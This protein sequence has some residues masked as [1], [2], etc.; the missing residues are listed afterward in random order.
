MHQHKSSEQTRLEKLSFCCVASINLVSLCIQFKPFYK[1]LSFVGGDVAKTYLNTA[2]INKASQRRALNLKQTAWRRWGQTIFVKYE[3]A[4]TL[5]SHT[6][7]IFDIEKSK[8]LVKISVCTHY[9]WLL[10]VFCIVRVLF[11]IYIFFIKF[12]NQPHP[13]YLCAFKNI[14]KVSNISE[15][16]GASSHILLS[17]MRNRWNHLILEEF[18]KELSITYREH[19]QQL[20]AKIFLFQRE[21]ELLQIWAKTTYYQGKLK[22]FLHII[23]FTSICFLK[24]SPA[25]LVK[26]CCQTG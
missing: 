2:T 13:L 9:P 22:L 11:N 10:Q 5:K 4:F 6:E 19:P 14:K 24:C 12:L 18:Q 26:R 8:V 1:Y 16:G 15:W 3:P 20:W 25:A 7:E 21:C 17:S 23:Y